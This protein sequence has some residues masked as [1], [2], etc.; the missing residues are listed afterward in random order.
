MESDKFSDMPDWDDER[1][2]SFDEDE[3]G[4]DW[5]PNLTREACKALFGKWQEVVFLLKGIIAPFMDEENEDDPMLRDMARDLFSDAHIVGAK[6]KS[7]D[8]G[9]IYV[10]RME[11]AAIIRKLAQGIASGLLL[12]I[13]DAEVDESYIHVVRNEIA[14]FRKLFIEWV[15]TFEKDEFVD[16]WGLFV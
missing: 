11:N 7:S 16:E 15:T 10:L 1:F 6:I 14:E 9:G 5:K 8:A 3:E 2:R 12:F 13:E 4:E